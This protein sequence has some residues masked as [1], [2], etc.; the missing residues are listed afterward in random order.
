VLWG[1][2]IGLGG[3]EV[4]IGSPFLPRLGLVRVRPTRKYERHQT[5]SKTMCAWIQGFDVNPS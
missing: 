3:F 2:E 5:G 1:F 4:D